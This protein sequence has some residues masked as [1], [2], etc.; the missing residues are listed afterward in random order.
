M[1]YNF[2]LSLPP[3]LELPKWNFLFQMNLSLFSLLEQLPTPNLVLL[4]QLFQVLHSIERHS[5]TNYMTSYNL[6]VC[7]TPSVVS[8]PSSHKLGLG[9]EVSKQVMYVSVLWFGTMF[10]PGVC[11]QGSFSHPV[12][13]IRRNNWVTISDLGTF[14]IL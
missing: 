7:I 11:M 14:L 9:N 10:C 6:S 12:I 2:F 13:S 4:R 1:L 8:L 3:C 5:S